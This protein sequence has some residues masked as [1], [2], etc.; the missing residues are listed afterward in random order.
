MTLITQSEAARRLGISRQ[1]V[2]AAVARGAI[3]PA[4]R[5]LMAYQNAAAMFTADEV[6]RYRV[7]RTTNKGGR[8]RKASA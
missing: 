6:E 4:N 3:D 1:A 2:A 8:P 7:A 5:D